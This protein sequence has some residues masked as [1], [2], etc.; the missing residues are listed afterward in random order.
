MPA[1]VMGMIKQLLD[2]EGTSNRS[3]IER[4]ITNKLYHSDDELMQLMELVAASSE[5]SSTASGKLEYAKSS[6]L[7]SVLAEV[8]IAIDCGLEQ[9]EIKLKQMQDYLQELINQSNVSLRGAIEIANVW[10]SNGFDAPEILASRDPELA[11]LLELAAEDSPGELNDFIQ[12]ILQEVKAI[13]G[14][15]NINLNYKIQTFLAVVPPKSRKE[16]ARIAVSEPEEIFGK[17]GCNLLLSKEESVRQGAIQGF[18]HRLQNGLLTEEILSRI[19]IVRPWVNDPTTNNE[20]DRISVAGLNAGLGWRL[21]YGS[22]K[23]KRIVTCIPNARGS[24]SIYV[25]LLSGIQTLLANIKIGEKSG[26]RDAFFVPTESLEETNEIFDEIEND[27]DFF[28]VPLEYLSV[29]CSMSIAEGFSNGIL[30][31]MGILDVLE[32]LKVN[33]VYPQKFDTS[34]YLVRADPDNM[35]AEFTERKKRILI[36][37]SEYWID[38]YAIVANWFEDD[39]YTD[40]I[41]SAALPLEQME[42][43][44]WK[45]LKTRCEYWSRVIARAALVAYYSK[46]PELPEF[47]VV[48]QAIREGYNLKKIPVMHHIFQRTL[49]EWD[50]KN[51]VNSKFQVPKIMNYKH[52]MLKENNIDDQSLLELNEALQY[53]DRSVNWLDGYI[54]ASFTAPKQLAE[55][56]FLAQTEKFVYRGKVQNISKTEQL[57]NNISRRFAQ[58]STVL[59]ES[60]KII[61]PSDMQIY[62]DWARGFLDCWNNNPGLWPR[63]V[64]GR[65]GQKIKRLLER[66]SS[67]KPEPSDPKVVASLINEILH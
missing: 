35:V 8:R 21:N 53:N 20:L 22:V 7:S 18:D 16:F 62:S 42:N 5:P 4:E 33:D 12:P 15:L 56:E 49:M 44:L 3:S 34:E 66:A 57:I 45:Y 9:G 59:T 58:I 24:Q 27:T 19:E 40:M 28:E 61:V 48:A 13:W 38:A 67:G 55:I 37:A 63:R 54:V 29:G 60:Q 32:T 51:N 1:S 25:L 10:I 6:I 65:K 14:A 2:S 46:R 41:I 39:E 30:P 11:E 36:R 52:P 17:I 31:E 23:I 26:V 43:E 64:L 47:L 50:A